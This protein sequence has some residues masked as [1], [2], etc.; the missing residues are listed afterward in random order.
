MYVSITG[1]FEG[2]D[3]VMI[4]GI[5]ELLLA[6]VNPGLQTHWLLSNTKLLTVLQDVQLVDYLKQVKQEVSHCRQD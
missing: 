1:I 4:I 2:R 5:Q 3:V 6:F